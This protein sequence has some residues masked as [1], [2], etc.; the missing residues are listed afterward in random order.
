MKVKITIDITKPV[1]DFEK[2]IKAWDCG[3]EDEKDL[4]AADAADRK[5]LQ[6][7]LDLFKKGEFKKSFNAAW[8]LDT[9]V[10]D[11]IPDSV[12]DICH[13]VSQLS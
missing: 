12:Y 13:N 11:Q 3:K 6:K 1:R 7:V 2:A 4:S 5:D 8:G 10:R 9:I